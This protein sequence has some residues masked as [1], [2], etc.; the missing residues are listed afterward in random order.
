[1]IMACYCDRQVKMQLPAFYNLSLIR[2]DDVHHGFQ[3]L[4]QKNKA[5][6]IKF[7]LCYSNFHGLK[8][9]A[10]NHK[11]FPTAKNL[12]LRSHNM[13]DQSTSFLY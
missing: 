12:K 5:T 4:S 11:E 8:M 10:F 7:Y 9:K 13:K 2:G 6:L 1:M 3:R